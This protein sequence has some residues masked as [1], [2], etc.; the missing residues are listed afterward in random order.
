MFTYTARYVFLNFDTA[1]D[2]H[3]RE[4]SLDAFQKISKVTKAHLDSI[5]DWIPTPEDVLGHI[6]IKN[7]DSH[8]FLKRVSESG[9]D[10]TTEELAAQ[11]FSA[12]VPT[13]APFSQAIAHVVDF[14]LDDDKRK[15]REEIVKLASMPGDKEAVGKLMV[16]VREALRFNPPVS[17]VYRTAGE[18]AIVEGKRVSNGQRIYASIVKANLETSTPPAATYDKPLAMAGILGLG[19]YGLLSTQFFE[20]TIPAILGTVLRLKNLKRAGKFTRFTEGY[21]DSPQQWYI[22]M[23]GDVTPFPCSLIVQF[24]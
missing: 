18:D 11:V 4:N 16:Y 15:E 21:H 3:L 2:W 20:S 5:R 24:E 23:Q 22:D 12:V 9:R 17:G 14:Y 10:L 6:A 7:H 8:D 19:E 13:A 1:N